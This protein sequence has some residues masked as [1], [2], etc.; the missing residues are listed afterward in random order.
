MRNITLLVI[1]FWGNLV[2]AVLPTPN[3]SLPGNGITM[4]SFKTYLMV[5][6]VTGATGYEFQY[7]TSAS[8]NTPNLI[9]VHSIGN[10]SYA[11]T[12]H[13]RK[14]STYYWRARAYKSGDTSN[15]SASRNFTVYTQYVLSAPANNS[16]GAL[17]EL[18]GTSAGDSCTY[19]FEADTS[20]SFT[21]PLYV[22]RNQESQIF[23]DSSL[24][25]FSRKIYWRATAINAFQDTL[26]WSATWNYTTDAGALPTKAGNFNMPPQT[27]VRWTNT[28]NTYTELLVDTTRDFS[29]PWVQT[30]WSEK[31]IGQDTLT[32]LFFG[33]KHFWKIRSHYGQ[34][35]SNWSFTDSFTVISQV[36]INS[37]VNNSTLQ[38]LLLNI[39]LSS[40]TMTGA[41]FHIQFGEDSLFGSTLLDT[42]VS[43]VSVDFA[44]TLKLDHVYHVRARALHDAD[45]SQ[46]RQN[47][48]RTFTGYVILSN[49]INNAQNQDVRLKLSFGTRHWAH[50]Y[51]MEVDT[52]KSFGPVL[53][54]EAMVIREF[55]PDF[56]GRLAA[57][58][59]FRYNQSYVYRVRAIRGDDTAAASAAYTFQTR[60]SPNPNFPGNG[61]IGIGTQTNALVAG[62]AGSDSIEFQLDTSTDFIS[63]Q[64]SQGV[65]AHVP[66]IFTPQYV[67]VEMPGNLLFESRYYW[68]TRCYSTIDTSEWSA[69]YSFTTTQRPWINEPQK[70]ATNV[71]VK[72]KLGWGIQGSSSD[73]IYQYQMATDS[74]F[75][76]TPVKSLA[77]GSSSEVTEN[78]AYAAR[79]YWRARALHDRDTSSWSEISWFTTRTPPTVPQ[80][81]LAS[82]R[83]GATN[84]PLPSVDLFWNPVSG[85]SSYDIQV[86]LDQDLTNLL[87]S[88]NALGTGA[89]FS[90]LQYNSRY[91]WRVR[92]R[93][94][95]LI[96]PWSATWN[97]TTERNVGLEE[98]PGLTVNVYPNPAASQ[99]F[100]EFDATVYT[101]LTIYDALGKQVKTQSLKNGNEAVDISDLPEGYYTMRLS[102]PEHEITNKLLIR[103]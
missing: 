14:G 91:Y 54:S 10:Q 20:P 2:W 53:S 96:G 51:L 7:D 66:D 5:S 18:F 93:Q 36:T 29:S 45:T 35:T 69:V 57:D 41:R 79:Y 52:G 15:W 63:P 85:A 80:V 64:L 16:T 48:F 3:L 50:S 67:N 9:S 58:T 98:N 23:G 13:L 82:P 65:V 6:S 78:C 17:R 81:L 61:F 8:F 71:A 12:Y 87:A 37:P 19:I 60:R 31:T 99:V 56:G 90:G 75:S 21:S 62:I 59:L 89:T 73:Y 94:D 38:D 95:T 49:P 55:I 92:A 97:F 43:G 46:W 26:N 83:N 72:P 101:H 68:R 102:G 77:A 1:L 22:L 84:I 4:N 40:T 70:N 103:R 27:I 42:F 32:N 47:R 25:G 74:S 11:Y 100:L 33:K 88:G 28:G 30:H 86:G 76:N 44:D 24:L 39:R 34:H